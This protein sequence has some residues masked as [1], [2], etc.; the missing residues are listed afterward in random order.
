MKTTVST[1]AWL[2]L[3]TLLCPGF[4]RAQSYPPSAVITAP[5]S[6]AYVKV[7]TNVVINVYATDIGK[8][9]NNGVVTKVEFYASGVKIGESSAHKN[10]TYSLTWRCEKAGEHLLTAKATNNSGVSFTSAGQYITAG[11]KDPVAIGMSSGRGKYVGNIVPGSPGQKYTQYWNG[12]TAENNC[13]WGTI[14][15]TRNVYKWGGADVA[16]NFA[17]DNNMMFRY[18]AIAWGNQ[19]PGWLQGIQNNQTEFKKELEEY[20]TLIASRY[21]YIDQADVLN[22]QI[23]TH[24]P[25]TQWFRNGLGGAGATGYD[26]AIYLFERARKHLPN[27]KLVLN[28]YGL[29]GSNTNIDAQLALAAVLR[30]RGLIDGY[31]TQAHCFN[32]DNRSAAGLKSDLDRMAKG[33]IPVYVTELDV[34]GSTEAVQADN[35][36][37]LFPVYWEHPSV[38]GITLWGYVSGQTWMTGTGILNSNGTERQALS[39]LKSYL[40]EK[41]KVGYPFS[42]ITPTT[43]D[44]SPRV[45]GISASVHSGRLNV[46]GATD[47]AKVSVYDMSGNLVARTGPH[48]GSLLHVHPGVLLVKVA[49]PSGVENLFRI[50]KY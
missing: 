11:S 23:G 40:L 36:K 25:N 9:K 12:V 41:P 34:R 31:G 46:L 24:A 50:I 45:L 29:E 43:A 49:D 22:E 14:E 39:Y 7:G 20:L 37:R 6:N 47:D 10:N 15:G 21:K 42:T 19:T 48:G 13:K 4:V 33:G 1:I 30:D 17:K 38:G 44:R 18:H 28:D 16:Y 5:H 35:Y 8:T 27:T 3:L 26:W 32:V 2:L